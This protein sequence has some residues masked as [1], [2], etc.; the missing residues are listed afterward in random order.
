M[1]QTVA[2][3]PSS[4]STTPAQPVVPP[5]PSLASRHRRP[6][7]RALAA[8]AV[9]TVI[10]LL[11]WF[12]W[13]PPAATGTVQA[14]GT[15]EANEIAIAAEVSARVTEVL[16]NEGQSVKAG[17]VLVQLDDSVPQLQA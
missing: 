9:I 5:D 7:R 13:L 15:L 3:P 4:A 1:T 16:A 8:L 10:G 2:A 14:V 6:P 12:R 11:T 17:E